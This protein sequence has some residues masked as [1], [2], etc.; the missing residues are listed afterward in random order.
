MS[1]VW[2]RPLA[3]SQLMLTRDGGEKNGTPLD[4]LK[5]API[6]LVRC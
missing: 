3:G 6:P 2:S 4:R 1:G 5:E